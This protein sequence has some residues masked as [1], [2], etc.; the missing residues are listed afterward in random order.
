[1]TDLVGYIQ[2]GE[3]KPIVAGTYSLED[4]KTGQQAF[5]DKTHTG[6]IVVVP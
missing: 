1:M 6:N 3:V 2:R 5:I 4:F